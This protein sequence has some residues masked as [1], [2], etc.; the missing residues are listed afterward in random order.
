MALKPF[1]RSGQKTHGGGNNR[2]TVITTT[3]DGRLSWLKDL[4][5]SI[6]AFTP[7]PYDLIVVD[8][9]TTDGTDQFLKGLK[10]VKTICNATNL[11]DTLGTNQA[12]QIAHTD[13]IVKI[14]TDTLIGDRGWWEEIFSLMEANP[15]IGI[16]GHVWN[17]GFLLPSRLYREGWPDPDGSL[18]CP[19]HVQGGFM[20]LRR[21]M[22]DQIGFFNEDYPH[23]G[24]DVELSHRAL[25]YGWELG[26]VPFVNSRVSAETLNLADDKV[27]HPVIHPLLR[28]QIMM[29]VRQASSC[30]PSPT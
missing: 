9:G 10:W 16:A 6:L 11:D 30:K 22:L 2:L 4:I 3:F 18:D 28:N 27:Y 21:Q 13:Y 26:P 5:G 20:V 15:K 17:P 14:D 7:P 12:L 23:L 29:R 8:N 1:K 24:M 19:D 25:S